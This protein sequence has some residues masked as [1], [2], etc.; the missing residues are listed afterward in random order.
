MH[1]DLHL[2]A[3][4]RVAEDGEEEDG[5]VQVLGNAVQGFVLGVGSRHLGFQSLKG[6]SKLYQQ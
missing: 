4:A 2:V 5:V 1:E 3:I 6:F